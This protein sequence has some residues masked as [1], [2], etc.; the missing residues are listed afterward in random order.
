MKYDLW[1][2]GFLKEKETFTKEDWE[3]LR[4]EYYTDTEIKEQE[5]YLK[6]AKS[7]IK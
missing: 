1:R 7:T 3:D 4:K 6:K 2:R 5:N